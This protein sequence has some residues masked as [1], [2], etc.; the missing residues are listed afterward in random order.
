VRILFTGASSFTGCWIARELAS[1][2]HEVVAALRGHPARYEGVRAERIRRLAPHVELVPDASFGSEE[3]VTLAGRG[4]WDL[5]CHHGACVDG[6][7]S[8]DFNVLAAVEQNTRNLEGVLSVLVAHGIRGVV[9]TGTVFE[10]DEGAGTEPRR[11]FS[12]YGLSKGMT[13]QVFAYRAAMA[14]VPLSKFVIPNPIGPFE[15]ARFCTY[16]VESWMRGET[17]TVRTPRYVRD[18]IH[19]SLL[20]RCY[21][22]LVAS[23]G[24]PDPMP[25]LAPSGYVESQGDFAR[26]VAREIGPRLGLA[27]PLTC[28][29]QAEFDE[30]AVRTN[31]DRVPEAEL[32]WDEATAWDGM[33]EFYRSRMTAGRA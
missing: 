15:D 10:P 5:L 30:P 8:P 32:G 24:S 31:T 12:L 9:L 2:G 16:L 27:A 4:P 18:N 28:A 21:A 29:E 33:A 11:A 17:P 13:G 23:F 25:R 1:A 6:Y 22:R 19:V 26:R 20:A 7:R 3:F 14:G